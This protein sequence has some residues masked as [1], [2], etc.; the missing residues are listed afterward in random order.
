MAMPRVLQLIASKGAT[1]D[2]MFEDADA[3]PVVGE[4]FSSSSGASMV[5]EN[6]Q[7]KGLLTQ[8]PG[9]GGSCAN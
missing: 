5:H 3:K 1:R 4:R 2:E 7:A 6:L 8:T 9:Q